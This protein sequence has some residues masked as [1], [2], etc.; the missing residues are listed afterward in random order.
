MLLQKMKKRIK[1]EGKQMDIIG[2]LD[3]AVEALDAKRI[4]ESYPFKEARNSGSSLSEVLNTTSLLFRYYFG[5]IRTESNALISKDWVKPL[6][7]WIGDRK[8]LEIMAGQGMLSKALQDEGVNIIATDKK[9][10][11]TDAW[12]NV[13]RLDCLK[14]I[15]KYGKDVDLIVCSWP[16]YDE[17]SAYKVLTLMREVNPQLMMIY[18]GEGCGGCCADNQFF[19][20][21][22]WIDDSSFYAAVEN[23]S[24]L[25]SFGDSPRLYR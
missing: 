25:P 1:L 2:D 17:D 15:Q 12:T 6:A 23:F 20:T 22:E 10:I 7:N 9:N 18:I 24:S 16:P 5:R 19:E 8:C 4:P 13:E 3:R 14:A 21:A 11:S